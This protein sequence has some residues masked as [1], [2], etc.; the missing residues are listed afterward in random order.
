[1]SPVGVPVHLVLF[2]GCRGVTVFSCNRIAYVFDDVRVLRHSPGRR[3]ALVSSP[4]QVL[5]GKLRG[6]VTGVLPIHRVRG[7]LIRTFVGALPIGVS[8]PRCQVT[9]Y[10]GIIWLIG[11]HIGIVDGTR[12]GGT[13]VTAPG[14]IIAYRSGPPCTTAI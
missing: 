7:L 12:N 13:L 2:G 3:A 11:G 1:M 14:R 10:V 8:G 6:L 4:V 5:V 9:A